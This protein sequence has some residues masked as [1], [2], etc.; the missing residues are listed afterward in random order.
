M[1]R[2]ARSDGG[3]HLRDVQNRWSIFMP[4]PVSGMAAGITAF[5]YGGIF[6][7]LLLR[8][9][10]N[11]IPD[12]ISFALYLGILLVGA[13]NV[14]RWL[15]ALRDRRV[16]LV[17]LGYL[18][19]MSA[20]AYLSGRHATPLMD[21][22]GIVYAVIASACLGA[23]VDD[24]RLWMRSRRG[25]Y[26]LRWLILPAAA[27][28]LWALLELGGV[29]SGLDWAAVFAIGTGLGVVVLGH[30]HPAA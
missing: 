7:S 11:P 1:A 21:S 23:V 28:G 13:S 26:R 10:W 15:P 5:A 24:V 2:P 4:E 6:L 25:D 30:R 12:L 3:Y 20:W 18:L 8:G 22:E 27:F 16:F 17:A 14:L 9:A 19:I 29:P